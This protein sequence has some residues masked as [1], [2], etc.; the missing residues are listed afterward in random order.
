MNI[1]EIVSRVWTHIKLIIILAMRKMQGRLQ[2]SGSWNA[3][4]G[5]LEYTFPIYQGW[6]PSGEVIRDSGLFYDCQNIRVDN[7]GVIRSRGGWEVDETYTG[8]KSTGDYGF[9]TDGDTYRV[10]TQEVTIAGNRTAGHLRVND[11][12]SVTIAKD[13]QIGSVPDFTTAPKIGGKSWLITTQKSEVALRQSPIRYDGVSPPIELT[14]YM[15]INDG[16]DGPWSGGDDGG[17]QANF[18]SRTPGKSGVSYKNRKYNVGASA[19]QLIYTQASTATPYNTAWYTVTSGE[20]DANTFSVG[21][22]YSVNSTG[23]P[24]DSTYLRT[25]SST[26]KALFGIAYKS[27]LNEELSGNSITSVTILIRGSTATVGANEVIRS[28]FYWDGTAYYAGDDGNQPAEQ[29][30]AGPAQ[31]PADYTFTY[32][33][34]PE[35]NA[36]TAT[37]IFNK[38]TGLGGE[39]YNTTTMVSDVRNVKFYVTYTETP[40]VWDLSTFD[41]GDNSS[42]HGDEFVLICHVVDTTRI[43]PASS[44]IRLRN[45]TTPGSNYMEWDLD[46]EVLASTAEGAASVLVDGWNVLVWHYD[47]SGGTKVT[48]NALAANLAANEMGSVEFIFE[49]PGAL[50]NIYID[51]F[52]A[53]KTSIF[54]SHG[55]KT[56]MPEGKYCEI[57]AN[58]DRLLVGNVAAK[59]ATTEAGASY[60]FYS[61]AWDIENATAATQYFTIA[62]EITAL[63]TYGEWTHIFTENGRY[64]AKP[65]YSQAAYSTTASPTTFYVQKAHGP[66]TPSH[67]SIAVGEYNGQPGFFFI[68]KRGVYFTNGIEALPVTRDMYKLWEDQFSGD[69]WY[70][71]SINQNGLSSSVATWADNNLYIAYTKSQAGSSTNDQML[72]LNTMAG[73]WAKDVMSSDMYPLSMYS[74]L[75]SGNNKI[76]CGTES[77]DTFKFDPSRTTLTDDATAFESSFQTPMIGVEV[78]RNLI[79]EELYLWVRSNTTSA[80]SLIVELYKLE[81]YDDTGSYREWEEDVG[82]A[83]KT[84]T[85]AFTPNT[86]FTWHRLKIPLE[87]SVTPLYPTARGMSFKIYEDNDTTTDYILEKVVCSVNERQY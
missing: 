60:V 32:T 52:Y 54:S 85:T 69:D 72:T 13:L 37:N 29:T 43:D 53:R 39:L 65:N 21:G 58:G 5:K 77:G 2:M 55:S 80:K 14:G 6:G 30:L 76:V 25:S 45:I 44:K 18:V 78:G 12:S 61:D 19:A 15:M 16:T 67:R 31:T 4:Q 7:N 59:S 68:S 40:S 75:E 34:D 57:T 84:L 50:T 49:S 8:G 51:S 42:D 24:D 20:L 74:V 48:G 36:W 28:G 47:D 41:W 62:G 3:V 23:S 27:A 11:G 38:L 22:H 71:D 63:K 70:D 64:V 83:Y 17:D 73:R 33:T 46:D 82:T 26:A 66:G 10:N 79:W 81:D 86:A 9:T 1:L 35:G 56:R 87:D